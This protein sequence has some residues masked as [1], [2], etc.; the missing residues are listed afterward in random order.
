MLNQQLVVGL[1]PPR[2]AKTARCW[3][4]NILI[5]R[6]ISTLEIKMEIPIP[7]RKRQILQYIKDNPDSTPQDVSKALGISVE[8]AE[9]YLFRLFRAVLVTRQKTRNPHFNYK[10]NLT[11]EQRLA[12][13]TAKEQKTDQA[14]RKPSEEDIKG[15][16]E[17]L[18]HD[19]AKPKRRRTKRR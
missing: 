15:S 11:G 7:H 10:V 9:M 6:N 4:R 2:G 19:E 5:D 14:Q 8:N 16:E 3:N 17:P 13:W 12:H 18:K 1:R